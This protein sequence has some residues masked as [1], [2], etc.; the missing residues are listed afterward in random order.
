MIGQQRV[1]TAAQRDARV[2]VITPNTARREAAAL[3][4]TQNMRVR[5]HTQLTSATLH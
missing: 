2:L 1:N 4:K 3:F 5:A